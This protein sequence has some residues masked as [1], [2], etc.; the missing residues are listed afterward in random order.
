MAVSPRLRK[1]A[2][3]VHVSCSV[4]WLGAAAAYL[5]LA[6]AAL[7][8]QDP[9]LV[10]AA[11]LAMEP[12]A[13]FALVPLA[14]ASLLTGLI[15]A[16]GSTWGLFRH[17]WVIFKLLLTVVATVVLI[18][19]MA[20]VTAL[21]GMAADV[22]S[23]APGGLRGQILHAGGGILVL[24]VTTV[25]GIYKPRGMTRYGRRRRLDKAAAAVDARD[26]ATIP[27]PLWVKVF[28]GIFIALAV[29]FVLL[30]VGRHLGHGPGAH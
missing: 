8:S 27:L 25:L 22:D 9:Q 17:Y 18:G 11:Y 7:T 5:A 10:R 23:P 19:N 29:L 12:T 26:D 15:A 24:L 13:R 6:I 3:T 16:L 14:F 20:T 2:L 28:R 30:R 4:G 1:L 21:A